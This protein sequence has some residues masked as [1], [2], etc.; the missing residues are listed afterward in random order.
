MLVIEYVMREQ[1]ITQS[2]LASQTGIARSTIS[3]I[4]TGDLP[5]YPKYQQLFADALNWEDKPC[6]LFEKLKVSGITLNANE[7]KCEG[8][9]KSIDK[10]YCSRTFVGGNWHYFCEECCETGRAGKIVGRLF[11]DEFNKQIGAE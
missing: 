11:K 7:I 1:G 5:P 2:K 4:F 8:C 10:Y 6:R 9:G 3:R